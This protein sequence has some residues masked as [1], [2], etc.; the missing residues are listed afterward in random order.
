[1]MPRDVEIEPGAVVE[2]TDG[3]LG[4]VD[5]VIVQPTTG[6]LS[7][8][9]LRRG[10]SGERLTIPATLIASIS[11]AREV[12]L[13]VD[14]DVARGQATDLPTDA[15]VARGDSG[16]I[17]IPVHAERLVPRKRQ[18]DLG[19]LRIHRRVEQSEE[20]VSQPV[21]RDDLVI[22][23]VPVNRPL[24][25]PVAPRD[26]GDWLVIPIME[27]VLVVRKQLMLKEEIRI[28]KRQVTE[29]QAVRELVRHEVVELEDATVYGIPGLSG[30][31]DAGP[32]RSRRAA[33]ASPTGGLTSDPA[34]TNPAVA[35][36]APTTIGPAPDVAAG[37]GPD[38]RGSQR[39]GPSR[40][41]Q[42]RTPPRRPRG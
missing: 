7:Y 23:R 2:A 16:Q 27:E 22:D 29:E 41:G 8:L 13:A 20:V 1:M 33:T 42:G 15:V 37:L 19:E 28:R 24:E 35:P 9:V 14:R 39:P 32:E 38:P 5:E 30:A 25:G 12:R 6:E 26:E 18:V 11:H 31:V 34:L 21:T 36:D 17:R 40:S 10:W 4:T 3:R